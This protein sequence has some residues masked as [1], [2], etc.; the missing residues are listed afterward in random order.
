MPNFRGG[1]GNSRSRGGNPMVPHPLNKSLCVCYAACDEVP[2][3]PPLMVSG[4]PCLPFQ[5]QTE[6][7]TVDGSVLARVITKVNPVTEDRQ[8]AERGMDS[9]TSTQTH[10]VT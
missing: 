2:S 9:T 1:G 7:T 5:L 8:V 6:Y 10:R 3:A 4:K